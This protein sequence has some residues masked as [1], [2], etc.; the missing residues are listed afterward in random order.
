MLLIFIADAKIFITD[1]RSAFLHY[2]SRVPV[3]RRDRITP[4][5]G[6]PA[7]SRGAI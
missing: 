6:S 7:A 3:L 5:T 2:F 1:A 4:K